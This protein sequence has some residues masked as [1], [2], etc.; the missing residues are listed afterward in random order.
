MSRSF[1]WH[2]EAWGGATTGVASARRAFDRRDGLLVGLRDA[3][4]ALSFGEATPLPGFGHDQLEDARRELEPCRLPAPVD[5]V[6]GVQVA[7][8]TIRSASARFAVEV[9]LL[10][11]LAR[12]RGLSLSELLGAT[13]TTASRSVL[14]GSLADD[15]FIEASRTA[16]RRGA[17]AV[18]L[19]ATG[20]DLAEEARRLTELG[21]ALGPD[22]ALRL[23]LNG[24]LDVS[25]A[26]VALG[27]YARAKVELCEEPCAGE[28]LLLLEDC[29]IPW[30]AD[31]SAHSDE[32]FG[33]FVAHPSCSGV[34]LK[35][36]VVGGLGRSLLRARDLRRAGKDALVTH[37][38]EGPV[39][40]A[41]VAELA[42]AVGGSRAHGV[43]RH[44]ALGAFPRA[45]L[46]QLPH[47]GRPLSV[48]RAQAPSMV[49]WE[50]S[51]TH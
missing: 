45:E 30:F 5:D 4:G 24:A 23:D 26:R 20:N 6:A 37:A 14:V 51:W 12:L 36:T 22:V 32:L 13:A 42:L 46:P 50:G 29:A 31:E 1:S 34:V 16:A 9:A 27:V 7:I 40:L 43:D 33:R 41:A 48:I 38:F 35:P 10:G 2:V 44:A 11:R 49:E 47:Q 8:S 17:R 3:D 21:R 15:E 18:K 28:A 39:A 19:K 25:G